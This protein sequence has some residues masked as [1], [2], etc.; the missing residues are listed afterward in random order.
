MLYDGVRYYD[1]RAHA[2]DEACLHCDKASLWIS[3]SAA[4]V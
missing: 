4:V 3:G 1:L 2:L